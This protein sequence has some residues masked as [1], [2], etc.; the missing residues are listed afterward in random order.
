MIKLDIGIVGL[1]VM[2]RSLALNM[3]DHGF[4]VG[5]YNR[6]AAVTEQVMRDHPHEN[7]IP[8]YDLKDMTDALARPRKVMLMIQAGKPVDAVIEQ[9]VPLLEKGDMILDGGN[10]FFEDVKKGMLAAEREYSDYGIKLNIREIKGYNACDIIKAVSDLPEDTKNVILTPV[11]DDALC[12]KIDEMTDSGINV[13]TLSS[14]ISDSKRLT[15]VGCD[16]LKSGETAGRLVGLLSGGKAN[17]CIV[18]GS[19][20][21]K[22]HKQRVEGVSNVIKEYKNI[23]IADVIENNDDNEKAYT[24]MKIVL[25]KNKNIDFVCITAGGVTGTLKAIKESERNIKVCSFDDT[26]TTRKAMLNGD[27]LATVYQQ[28]FEQGYNAVKSVFETVV[29]KTAVPEY[30]YSQLYIK[31]DK[32]L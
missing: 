19:L 5:G 29:A 26:E 16:Y 1:S 12:K 15:Y 4:K 17:L 27:I 11:E 22:G 9:L 7:L 20:A 32:S 2:G 21:H 23:Q 10:S 14:D 25:G 31:V 8:F 18:T 30:Q 3:A 13:I 6:S 24:A 28:P